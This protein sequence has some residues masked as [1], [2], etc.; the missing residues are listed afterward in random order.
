VILAD[1][2]ALIYAFRA[3]TSRHT[4]CRSWLERII[5]SETRFCLSPLVLRAVARITTNPRI[6]R[7]AS[8][9]EE[10]LTYCDDFPNRIARSFNPADDIGQSS[11]ACA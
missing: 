7:R 3:D 11:G 1:V 5:M 9:I 2:N 6:F 10:A 4:L 8:A